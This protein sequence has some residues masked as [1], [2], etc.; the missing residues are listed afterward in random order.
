MA[1]SEDLPNNTSSQDVDIDVLI[2]S[3]EGEKRYTP[4]VAYIF[5]NDRVFYDKG[6]E[7]AI[8]KK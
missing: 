1:Q 4:D 7:S 5:S 8:Y 2:D 6:E 3:I